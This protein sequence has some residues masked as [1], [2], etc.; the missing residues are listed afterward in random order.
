MLD[1]ELGLVRDDAGSAGVAVPF[2]PRWFVDNSP[3]FNR[4]ANLG[5]AHYYKLTLV[6]IGCFFAGIHALVNAVPDSDNNDRSLLRIW[7]K[8]E[9]KAV[10]AEALLIVLVQHAAFVPLWCRRQR[11]AVREE[12]EH[13][14]WLLRRRR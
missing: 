7:M 9:E 8:P 13:R 2:S 4:L 10:L 11:E 6:L 14:R 12:E 3:W 1:E 5:D